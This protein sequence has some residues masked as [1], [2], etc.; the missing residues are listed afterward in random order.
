MHLSIDLLLE[1]ILLYEQ[2]LLLVPAFASHAPA[3]FFDRAIPLLKAQ[4]RGCTD[5]VKLLAASH[6]YVHIHHTQFYP[7]CN[8]PFY[9]VISN[10]EVALS[11]IFFIRDF[12]S[13]YVTP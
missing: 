4:V 12:L 13:F 7:F 10:C 2:V 6:V 9:Y 8:N 3:S 5:I 11:F 1:L